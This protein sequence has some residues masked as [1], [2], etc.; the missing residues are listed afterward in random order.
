MTSPVLNETTQYNS[1][2][3]ATLGPCA[4][5]TS[6]PRTLVLIALAEHSSGVSVP[7][8][9][10]SSDL[11]WTLRSSSVDPRS[12]SQLRVDTYSAV[13]ASAL[14]SVNVTLTYSVNFDDAVLWVGAFENCATGIFDPNSSVPATAQFASAT[15]PSFSGIST[16]NPDDYLIFG[17]GSNAATPF[18]I[19]PTGFTE[20]GS[21]QNGGGALWAYLQIAGMSVSALQSAETFTWGDAPSGIMQGVFDVLTADSGGPP[22]A[23]SQPLQ[24]ILT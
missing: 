21:V 2:S 19:A 8:S 24:M 9:V 1:S 3:S 5:T 10:V 22:V 18:G 13:A 7:S 16:S 12:P 4:I 23:Q 20:I 6:G 17:W 11:T 15:A 14:S